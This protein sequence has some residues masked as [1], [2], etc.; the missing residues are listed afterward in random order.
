MKILCRHNMYFDQRHKIKKMKKEDPKNNNGTSKLCSNPR[1]LHI[2]Q[3]LRPLF[4]PRGILIA[5]IK[6]VKK[7][8]SKAIAQIRKP[9]NSMLDIS[10]NWPI[11]ITILIITF[12]GIK[13]RYFNTGLMC[14]IV[15]NLE[16][17]HYEKSLFKVPRTLHM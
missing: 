9:S 7:A 1:H 4:S 12:Q 15:T 17:F 8:A 3:T 11:Q 5:L 2:L 13:F 10:R 16:K 14:L 6:H